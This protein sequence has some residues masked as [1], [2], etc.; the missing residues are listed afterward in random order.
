MERRKETWR[1]KE[2]YIWTVIVLLYI[3]FVY[4]NSLATATVSSMQ[5]GRVL[6]LLRAVLDGLGLDN[7]WMTEHIVRKTAHFAEYSML[8]L[9]L[10]NCVRSYR[11]DRICWISIQAFLTVLIPLIDETLQLFSAGRSGQVDDVW[12]DV[13]GVCFGTACMILL[14]KLAVSYKRH[15]AARKQK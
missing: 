11:P 4:H 13:A 5:S 6:A 2:R 8:G 7:T 12:L 3:G 15:K 1:G 9:L 14:W 10:W